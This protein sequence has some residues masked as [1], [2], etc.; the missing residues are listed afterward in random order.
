MNLQPMGC[1]SSALPTELFSH[2]TSQVIFK[3]VSIVALIE[4]YVN[5][6]LDI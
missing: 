4:I 3:F 1:E 6:L 2:A 5:E